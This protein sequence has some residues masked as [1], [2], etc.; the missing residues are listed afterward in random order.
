MRRSF[1]GL[2]AMKTGTEILGMTPLQ[3][4]QQLIE[5]RQILRAEGR[6]GG[7]PILAA[8]GVGIGDVDRQK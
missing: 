6:F 2:S 5:H 4:V 7:E 3:C 1:A 8:E